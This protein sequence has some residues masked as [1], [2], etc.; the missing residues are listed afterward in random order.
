MFLK[1][2]LELESFYNAGT[3]YLF[4]SILVSEVALPVSNEPSSSGK[5]SFLL[6]FCHQKV[7]VRESYPEYWL[8]PLHSGSILCH[9]LTDLQ[10]LSIRSNFGCIGFL[11][12]RAEEYNCLNSCVL[13]ATG[14]LL[15]ASLRSCVIF[16]HGVMTPGRIMQRCIDSLLTP[17]NCL[18]VQEGI[19][20]GKCER[21]RQQNGS[22]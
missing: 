16:D 9:V 12:T 8:S 4:T 20:T 14:S 1:E 17:V 5:L 21:P 13:W 11:W 10:I 19:K 3:W 2:L 6:Q 15:R 22:L 18:A 7:W